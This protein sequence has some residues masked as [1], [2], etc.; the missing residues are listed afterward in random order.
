MPA[1]CTKLRCNHCG[2]GLKDATVAECHHCHSDLA[3][4][5]VTSELIEPGTTR[6]MGRSCFV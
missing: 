5:G 4:V 2:A 1:L 6:R 3:K